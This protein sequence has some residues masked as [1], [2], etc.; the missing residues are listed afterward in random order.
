MELELS[1]LELLLELELL[2]L[3]ELGV[4]VEEAAALGE[5]LGETSGS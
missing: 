4:G 1:E 3:L 5:G 2:E